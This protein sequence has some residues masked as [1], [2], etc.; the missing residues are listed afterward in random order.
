MIG[1]LIDTASPS[2]CANYLR[3]S[4]YGST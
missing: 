4:G 1:Q 3:N 2:E